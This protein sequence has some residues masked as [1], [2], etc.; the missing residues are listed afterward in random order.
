M[1]NQLKNK[2]RMNK[3]RLIAEIGSKMISEVKKEA[4]TIE[5]MKNK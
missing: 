5:K 4:V 3:Q 2:E 1:F